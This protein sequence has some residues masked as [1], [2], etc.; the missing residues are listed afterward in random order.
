MARL[1]ID[2]EALALIRGVDP[3][4]APDP[5]SVAAVA[6][7]AG[8]E[9]IG[10]PLRPGRD[11]FQ[12]A[13]LALL[14]RAVQAE[15]V[16]KM[17]PATE[18]LAVALEI[19]PERVIIVADTDTGDDRQVA[20]DLIVQDRLLQEI[21]A[22][23]NDHGIT[24]AVAV[25]PALEQIKQAHKLGVP[26]IHLAAG[27]KISPQAARNRGRDDSLAD[28]I[29]LARKLRLRVSLSQ[30]IDLKTACLLGLQQSVDEIWVGR[31]F[32]SQ[33]LLAGVKIAVEQLQ[34]R[35]SRS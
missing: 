20:P 23:L 22:T 5:L 4:L 19:R 31:L 15:L 18:M 3:A 9:V 14:R 13:E 16:L 2:I 30:N 8:A 28:I 25:S 33:A 10:A 11:F 24:P 27:K 17:P 34:S 32:C 7:A 29:N 26:W 1:A 6:E 21:V 35:L 12:D